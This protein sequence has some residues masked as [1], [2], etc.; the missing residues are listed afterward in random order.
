MKKKKVSLNDEVVRC[1]LKVI[2][3]FAIILITAIGFDIARL[4]G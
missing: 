3:S 1:M 4:I 2:G